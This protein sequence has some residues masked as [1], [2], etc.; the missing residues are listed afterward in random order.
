[1]SQKA[2]KLYQMPFFFWGEGAAQR[3]NLLF[4]AA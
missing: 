2:E 4:A 1:M 3:V